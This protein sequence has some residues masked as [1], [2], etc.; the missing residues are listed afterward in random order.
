[1]ARSKLWV[2]VLGLMVVIGVFSIFTV[3]QWQK[4]ILFQLGKVVSSDY[5]AGLQFK[6]PVIQNV[7][8]FDARLQT[9]ESDPELY[10]TSEKKNVL[11]DSFVL[12]RVKNV[13]SFY[14]ATGGSIARAG[15]RLGEFVRKGLKDEFGKRT[16]QEVV[17][18]K[19]ADIMDILTVTANAQAEPF[20][21]EIVDV[22]VKRIDLPTEVSTSVY[23]RM[24][25]ERQRVARD[26]RSRGE[27]E[28]K[29][30]RARAER[31]REVILAEAER[32]AQ[33]VRGEGDGQAAE[34]YA[35]AYGED[36]EFYAFYRSLGA[37][38][39]SFDS[40]SDVILLGPDNDFFRY[41]KSQ[42]G[43]Q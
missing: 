28:A 19:R 36:A 42:K 10:L 39:A 40:P 18:G 7:E 8:K 5:E 17:S 9:L 30:I 37:Y 13:E 24:Q 6:I 41:F 3:E 15:A 22:R 1:M 33:R 25:A 29:R 2:F 23:Q 38:R 16:I 26:F 31:E 14:T 4:A 27:E 34:T 21:I 35:K 43:G 11:V 32:D 20:G 12:W